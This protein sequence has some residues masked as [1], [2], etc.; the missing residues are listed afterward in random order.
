MPAP[1]TGPMSVDRSAQRH[2]EEELRRR[3]QVEVGRADEA[4]VIRPQDASDAREKTGHDETQVTVQPGVEAQALHPGF[5]LANPAQ[6]QPERRSDENRDRERR[7]RKYRQGDVVEG[8]WSR[9]GQAGVKLEPRDAAQPVVS[10][11]HGDPP[12]A[13][14]PQHHANRQR[15][16]QEIHVPDVRDDKPDRRAQQDADD[17]AAERR[18]SRIPS[19][20]SSR[21]TPTA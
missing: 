16:H 13:Q 20:T 10:A 8:V 1:R 4:V 12:V 2:H 19:G 9:K 5:V 21:S 14:T 11:R 18:S 15:D 6:R 7:H 3:G 17:D